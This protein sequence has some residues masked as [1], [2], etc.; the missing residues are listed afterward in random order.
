MGWSVT[1]TVFLYLV[2]SVTA[3]CFP[4]SA[5]SYIWGLAPFLAALEA[6]GLALA[7]SSALNLYRLVNGRVLGTLRPS[8]RESRSSGGQFGD[9]R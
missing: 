4:V 7:M 6:A 8:R 3:I 9:P 1:L 2:V 5:V